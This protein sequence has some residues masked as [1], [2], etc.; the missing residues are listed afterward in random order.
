MLQEQVLVNRDVLS[1]FAGVRLLCHTCSPSV[2]A[3]RLPALEPDA[4]PSAV[5]RRIEFNGL[6]AET[7][8]GT[9]EASVLDASGTV[10]EVERDV[11]Q[12]I[13]AQLRRAAAQQ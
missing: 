9:P 6:L 10:D 13:E 12:W 1:Y 7:G 4:P 8:A 5:S 11:R 2:V 3:K